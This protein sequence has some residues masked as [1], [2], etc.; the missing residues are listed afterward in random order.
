MRAERED[1]DLG[2][3][4]GWLVAVARAI[5]AAIGR[6]VLLRLAAFA[7]VLGLALLIEFALPLLEG[8]GVLSHQCSL[9]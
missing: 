4:C 7:F 6:C 5:A 2:F 1:R 3:C 9:T 8:V